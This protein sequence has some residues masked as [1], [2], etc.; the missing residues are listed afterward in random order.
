MLEISGQIMSTDIPV[1]EI[2]NGIVKSVNKELAPL[3]FLRSLDFTAWLES[4][5][6]DSHRTNSRLLKKALR[7]SNKDDA[8][9]VL[10]VNAV[11]ITD[12]YWFKESGSD[13]TWENVRFKENF[14]DNLAL[15]GDFESFNQ[16]VSRTPE[17][18]NIGSFEKCWRLIDNKWWLYKTGNQLEYF[19]E[20]FIAKL[21][22]KLN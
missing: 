13:L 8:N 15:C 18:T 16:P 11:T 17:L 2:E 14:F 10:A 3:F 4:R 21:A 9:T 22:E 1:V 7:L 5:A 12:N 6:I 19:S 20:L